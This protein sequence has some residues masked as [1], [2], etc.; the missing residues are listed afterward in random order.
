MGPG[1]SFTAVVPV[2]ALDG[3]PPPGVSAP[4]LVSAHCAG[5]PC[6]CCQ[7]LVLQ[8]P[9]ECGWCGGE[10]HEPPRAHEGQR[11]SS[12]AATAAAG[13]RRCLVLIPAAADAI[14]GVRCIQHTRSTAAAAAAVL[15]VTLP[16]SSRGYRC[17]LVWRDLQQQ[18]Q[19]RWFGA[20]QQRQQQRPSN[21]FQQSCSAHKAV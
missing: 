12:T 9:S 21:V 8:G 11:T 17:L 18:Q 5:G 15:L 20:K 2:K 6:L 7:P 1:Q 19:W 4:A 13:A 3:S 14:C 16:G 10:G